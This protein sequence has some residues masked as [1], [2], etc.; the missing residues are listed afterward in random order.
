MV[1]VSTSL[2]SFQWPTVRRLT[3]TCFKSAKLAR[4][5]PSP[6][7]PYPVP[8]TTTSSTSSADK[9]MITTNSMTFGSLMSHLT[10]GDK[11]KS[12]REL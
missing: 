5:N 12:Q 4:L 7:L 11:F 10:L 2:P 1:P 9:M 3:L 6:E 8:P